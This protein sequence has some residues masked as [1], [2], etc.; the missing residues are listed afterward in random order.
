M[1]KEFKT[2]KVLLTNVCLISGFNFIAGENVVFAKSENVVSAKSDE[3][4]NKEA[5]CTETTG[6]VISGTEYK[7]FEEYE[8][9]NVDKKNIN[10]NK[11]EDQIW[12]KIFNEESVILYAYNKGIKVFEQIEKTK[13]KQ[14]LGFRFNKNN[15]GDIVKEVNKISKKACPHDKNVL[16]LMI[17]NLLCGNKPIDFTNG[18][19]DIIYALE[20]TTIIANQRQNK[21][22][23][24]DEETINRGKNYISAMIVEKMLSNMI[25]NNFSTQLNRNYAV[26]LID[27]LDWVSQFLKDKQVLCNKILLEKGCEKDTEE[28]TENDLLLC[29]VFYE[30][31]LERDIRN[32]ISRIFN[33]SLS[34]E[35]IIEEK[36]LVIEQSPGHYDLKHMFPN[37]YV[38]PEYLLSDYAKYFCDLNCKNMKCIKNLASSLPS[39]ETVL[40]LFKPKK[41]FDQVVSTYEAFNEL[42]SLATEAQE[43]RETIKKLQEKIRDQLKTCKNREELCKKGNFSETTPY[44]KILE[45]PSIN[46]YLKLSR[47]PKYEKFKGINIENGVAQPPDELEHLVK[48]KADKDLFENIKKLAEYDNKWYIQDDKNELKDGIYSL[49]NFDSKSAT[50]HAQFLYDSLIRLQK[51]KDSF[52]FNESIGK[53]VVIG[54]AINLFNSTTLDDFIKNLGRQYSYDV[55]L[56]DS[57]D[58]CIIDKYLISTDY[59]NDYRDHIKNRFCGLRLTIC[60]T[61]GA[62]PAFFKDDISGLEK[63]LIPLLKHRHVI[64]K[65][66]GKDLFYFNTD[67]IYDKKRKC[68]KNELIQDQAKSQF[69]E[70]CEYGQNNALKKYFYNI[71]PWIHQIRSI[72]STFYSCIREF[73]FYRQDLT[74]VTEHDNQAV[75]F[76]RRDPTK[77][78]IA[79]IFCDKF[80]DFGIKIFDARDVYSKLEFLNPEITQI[81]LKRYGIDLIESE[82][83]N[84]QN[85]YE[86]LE[87]EASQGNNVLKRL[88]CSYDDRLKKLFSYAVLKYI[89]RKNKANKVSI[90]MQKRPQVVSRF[91]YQGN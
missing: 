76:T 40:S 5:I 24:A 81:K 7:S 21:D 52:M 41:I 78:K 15:L 62:R 13:E 47:S 65:V 35:G 82:T 6:F 55:A 71:L 61:G 2:L 85:T 46:E 79:G 9:K 10:F 54:E 12:E 26:A 8:Q 30:C 56:F 43:R 34:I 39:K 49:K 19:D 80:F 74:F 69:C 83:N 51:L 27:T 86:R 90:N 89:E 70:F 67:T 72:A 66:A 91:S 23:C 64:K 36:D 22:H 50:K 37:T 73:E 58:Q 45:N 17:F 1:I 4:F 31:S 84:L 42:L 57:L 11:K 28:D 29:D 87:F 48:Y 68:K 75:F 20:N 53:S 60:Q 77:N 25:T 16:A 14:T 3:V 59:E 38:D 18:I 88:K 33:N 32:N 44:T 63:K